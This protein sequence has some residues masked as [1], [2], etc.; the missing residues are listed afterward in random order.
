MCAPSKLSYHRPPLFKASDWR[1]AG[2]DIDYVMAARSVYYI[3]GYFH[4][5]TKI[6]TS[7]DIHVA[8]LTY[9][10]LF[11]E[12]IGIHSFFEADPV[13]SAEVTAKNSCEMNGE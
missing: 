2:Q 6:A 7:T 5:N 3:K 8:S 13:W 4:P 9:L 12:E 1:P 10:V 11:K